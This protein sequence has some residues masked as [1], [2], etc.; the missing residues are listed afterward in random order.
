MIII[1]DNIEIKSEIDKIWAYLIDF[2]YS[3]NF[4][5]F[6][7]K[8]E[9][10]LN[11]SISNIDNFKINHNFGF[12][13]YEM[14]VEIDDYIA[15]SRLSLYEY[16]IDDPAKGFPHRVTYE[17]EPKAEQ[18]NLVYSLKGSCGGKMQDISFKPILKGVIKEELI[19]IK[20]AIE[21]SED[22]SKQII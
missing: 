1:K 5:R 19:K 9:L 15:P 11:Y 14:V 22:I 2:K 8:I 18:C 17:I 21:S 7:T 10:P 3:L 13:K 16:C 6:H 12:G 20:D 4:N